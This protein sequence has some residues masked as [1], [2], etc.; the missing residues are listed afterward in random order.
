LIDCDFTGAVFKAVLTL[1]WKPD[2]KTVANT[3]FIYTDYRVEEVPT[4]FQ[5]KVRR[6]S[7]VLESRVPADGFFGQG[8]HRKFTMADYL[9]EPFR[10]N[11]ALNVPAIFRTAVA[12][13]LQFFTDFMRVT[14][15][16]PLEIRTRLEGTKMRVE[17]LANTE[18]DLEAVKTTFEEYRQNTGRDFAELRLNISF[19]EQTS[20]LEQKLFLLEYER[21]L[22]SL[23]T[24]LSLTQALLEQSQEH[25]AFLRRLVEAK[26]EPP[27][28]LLPAEFP[29]HETQ[30]FVLRA[31]LGNY[32]NAVEADKRLESSIQQFVAKQQAAIQQRPG[33]NMVKT[34]G[35]GLLV[36]FSDAVKLIGVATDLTSALSAFKLSNP[37]SFGGFRFVFGYGN[38][39]CLQTGE[40]RE[41]TGDAVVEVE[42][43]DQPMKRFLEQ[44]KRTASEMWC[45]NAFRDQVESKHQNLLFE[46]LPEI[47]LDKGHPGSGP[48]FR[49]TIV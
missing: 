36:V 17:F 33:C 31:D 13:Y 1:G 38:L 32:S 47:E 39:T 42:R 18:P 11:L 9:R 35:D 49:V 5:G 25:A 46:Q 3:N 28:L 2:R 48:L 26:L 27:K 37:C 16:I 7:P 14:H 34:A 41:Y 22:D 15:G 30:Q 29:Q 6:Y 20:P 10:W 23:K 4:E 21:Q 45:T 12:N 44:E 19:S 40:L 8:E 24:K 43:I